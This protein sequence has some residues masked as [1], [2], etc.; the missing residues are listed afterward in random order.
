[1]SERTLRDGF[2]GSVDC[3]PDRDA[4][5]IGGESYSYRD[6]HERAA[7][8]AATLARHAPEDGKL[9]AVFG[10]RHVSTFAGILAALLRGHGYVPMNPAFPVDRTRSMLERS[11]C[12]CLVVD[13]T[14]QG[15][16]A[17]LL[18]G[19][20]T[21]QVVLLPDLEDTVE[22]A[23]R[24][25]AH[26]FLG[27]ADLEPDDAMELGEASPDDLCYLL[28]TSGSTGRPK[29]VM[30]AHRNVTAFVDA[31]VER[32]EIDEN[33]RFSNTFDLTFDLS[34]TAMVRAVERDEL[35]VLDSRGEHGEETAGKPGCA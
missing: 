26:T 7:S 25:P 31:M 27:A 34:V 14:A 28:F 11:R 24:W 9:T 12:R 33:D 20:E 10:H 1:V 6:L 35:A 19:I 30:V 4:L 18:E 32:Y 16:L 8:I 29:G 21:P 5:S 23:E 3:F 15:L 2:L 22:L 13:P 17:T